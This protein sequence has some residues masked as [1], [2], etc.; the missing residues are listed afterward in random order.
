MKRAWKWFKRIVAGVL[1]LAVVAV[2]AVLILLHTDWGREQVRKR[3]E[4][5]LLDQFPGGAH[6][7]RLDGSIFGTLVITNLE[8]DGVDH[9]P[10]ISV[11]KLEVKPAILPL[12]WKTVRVNAVIATDVAI[13]WRAQPAKPPSPSTE[14]ATTS[15][16]SIDLQDIEVHRGKVALAG[17]PYTIDG[18][19]L[20]AAFSML[21]GAPLSVTASVHGMWVERQ[22]PIAAT[23]AFLLD[24]GLPVVPSGSIIVGGVSIT[25]A[26]VRGETGTIVVRGTA[27]AIAALDPRVSLPGNVLI[28]LSADASHKVD[29]N[30]AIGPTPIEGSV[31]L[32][33]GPFGARGTIGTHDVDL[34]TLTRGKIHG[35]G[36]AVV[37]F[38]TNGK[39]LHATI[40]AIPRIEGIPVDTV[41]VNVD[42]TAAGGHVIAFVDGPGELHAVASADITPAK[43]TRS[44]VAVS[45]ADPSG[46][47]PITG[48]LRANLTASGPF[49]SLA[50]TGTAT[51]RGVGYQDARVSD[52][53]AQF[54]GRVAKPRPYGIAH[55]VAT[56]ITN[57]RSVLGNAVIDVRDD[58]S[59]RFGVTVHADPRPKLAIDLD[60]T[61]IPQGGGRL[62]VDLGNHRINTPTALFSGV[63]GHVAVAPDRVVLTDLRTSAGQ[64]GVDIT[65]T[66]R[67]Y[68]KDL[69]AT[70]ALTQVEI[71][72][73]VPAITGHLDGTVAIEKRGTAWSGKGDLTGTGIT[74]DGRLPADAQLHLVLAGRKLTATATATNG[75][76]GSAEIALDLRGPENPFDVAGWQRVPRA[77]IHRL[78][79]ALHK[80]SPGAVDA[81]ASGTI[82]GV[83]ELTPTDSKGTFEIRGVTVPV[84]MVDVDMTVVPAGTDELGLVAQAHLTDVG[85]VDIGGRVQLPDQLF[86]APA[87]LALGRNALRGFSA[88][89]DE[90]DIDPAMLARFH[91][92]APYHGRAMIQLAVGPGGETSKLGLDLTGLAG[93]SIVKPLELHAEISTSPTGT[94]A[95]A[96]ASSNMH[97]LLRIDGQIPV[98]TDQW[99]AGGW[100]QARTA[101]LTGTVEIPSV[102]AVELLAIVGRTHLTGGSLGGKATIGGTLGTPTATAR[103]TAHDI[104]VA[105]ELGDKAPPVLKE[106]VLVASWGGAS[107]SID[108]TGFEA[109]GGRM[110]IAAQGSPLALADGTARLE[111]GKLDLVPIAAFLPGPYVS[112]AGQVDGAVTVKGFLPATAKLGGTATIAKGRIPISP[113]IGTLQGASLRLTLYE[114]DVEV[115]LDADLGVNHSTVRNLHVE[116]KG[117]L[118]H[119]EA[120]ARLRQVSPINALR[121]IIDADVE[122]K[123]DRG[124]QWT[125]TITVKNG[126]VFVPSKKGTKLLSSST[127]DD[128]VFVDKPVPIAKTFIRPP[129]EH[130]TIAVHV[131]MWSTVV[132]VEDIA[133]TN[134]TGQIDVTL[135]GG[136]IGMFGTVDVPRG[137]ADLF[138][139]RYDIDH[140]SVA[141]DGTMDGLI[142]VRLVHDFPDMTLVAEIGGRV[143]DP[144]IDLSSSPATY[145]RGQLLGFL[146]GGE[147]S[148][149]P[150]QAATELAYGAGSAVASSIIGSKVRQ[151]IKIIDVLHCDTSTLGTSCTVGKWIN[152]K[153][154]ISA[155][156]NLSARPDENRNEGEGQYYL[157]RNILLDLIGGDSSYHSLDVLWRKR[158]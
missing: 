5:V 120:T 129:P 58:G 114:R 33:R 73:I 22:A 87:W 79:I 145:T 128:L 56:G 122:A 142:N 67:T 89:M 59:G 80:I 14:P 140:G 71:E 138:N 50:F 55:V 136:G 117:D 116:A 18:L 83:L 104:A 9:K 107:G 16:W 110:H 147:P 65:A 25:A 31:Q 88:Q 43:V 32:D 29:I 102:S 124:S 7:G 119:I 112:L 48:A 57:D 30:G 51:G 74:R 41:V 111:I 42:G 40:V 26:G 101:E 47:A 28:E 96:N 69:I 27:D 11:G 135:G 19:E 1:G 130:P 4:A 126:H 10:L 78:A 44:H 97:E 143:S 54:S 103:F 53:V 92:D 17:Q 105:A 72:E 34:E 146:L 77:D 2:I 133:R 90:V 60:A 76:V 151:V 94:S 84:G 86:D 95:F 3:V 154:F 108:I 6:I 75:S 45:I 123:L 39:Q 70:A 13:D 62:A 139:R 134:V 153:L 158:W 144:Q 157:K 121:P 23:F 21:S 49:A 93:G 81:R 64:G 115:V 38:A 20:G 82:D 132:E 118:S 15:P 85:T 12:L 127:P 131:E 63:G 125:G 152:D 149:D 52:L 141:F 37:T 61:V 8:L 137:S 35:G 98:T 91:I 156:A 113:T 36:D 46:F 109:D 100:T 148:G 66:Y 155:R 106:L 99:L 150:N 68:D 24:D